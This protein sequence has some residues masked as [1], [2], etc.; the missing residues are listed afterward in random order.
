[1]TYECRI[2]DPYTWIP[3]ENLIP[4]AY[5]KGKCRNAPIAMWD[6]KKFFYIR[7]K[8][9]DTFVEEINCPED[10][11]GFDVFFAQELIYNPMD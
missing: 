7:R 5:Y 1:M 3:K 2:G 9:I 6:G 10:D 11:R 8:F 4:F